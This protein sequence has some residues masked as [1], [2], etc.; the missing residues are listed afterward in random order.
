VA[1]GVF[2]MW[3]PNLVA[4]G[5]NGHGSQACAVAYLPLALYFWDRLWR[6]QGVLVNGA[7]L[8]ITFGF[9]ML[10]AH[11]Q[12]SYYTYALVG[13][14]AVFFGVAHIVDAARGRR[15]TESPLP[16]RLRARLHAEGT[17]PL[18]RAFADIGFAAFVLAVVVAASLAMCAVLYLP[19][20]DYARY[21]I[22]GASSAGGLDYGYAT[23]WSLHPSE[24]LTFLVPHSFGFGKELYLG[25]MP[26]TD[27]P[28]Y[29]GVVV[30]AFAA[31]ALAGV[32]GRWVG[33]AAFVATVST[34][35]SFGKFLPV[36]YDPMF[37]FLP[38]FSKFRVPVMV[39]IV[40]QLAMVTLFAAGA[41]ALY[42][43][44]G[45]ERAR[46][47]ALRGL[48]LAGVAFLAALF[49]QGYWTGGFVGAAAPHVRA[50]QDPEQQRMVARLAGEF[51]AR[52][53]VQLSAIGLA[54]AGAVFAFAANR[55]MS[56][57]VLAGVVLVLG[58]TDYYRVDRFILH[59]EVFRSH[60]AYR[61]LRA[62]AETAR[63]SQPDQMVEALRSREGP[64][65]IFPMDSPQRPFS[66]FFTTN[67]FM[68]FGIESIG[69]YHPAKL[70]LYEEYMQALAGG[71][72]QGRFELLD[73]MNVR[74]LVTG[75]RLPEQPRF[76]PVWSGRDFEGQSRV[77]YEN[78]GAFPRAWVVG[79]YRVAGREETP[80]LLVGGDID[81]RRVAV[82]ERRPAIEPVPGDSARVTVTRR[83][84]RELVLA[85]E[86]DRP[87]LVVVSEVYYPDWKAAVD[88]VA[89]EVLRAN[90]VLRA[91]A[92]EAGRHE[93]VFSYD[94][95]LL[96]K[97][98]TA[99]ITAFALTA[100][101]LVGTLLGGWKGAPWKR[102]S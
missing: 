87:G 36:L 90:H 83:S 57:G 4:V 28:N 42:T 7:A 15:A 21:S 81:L 29:L 45:G 26:F 74:Y 77:I 70:S 78:A 24:M 95:S 97:S 59:P 91:V 75:T 61:V 55:R 13:L 64:F 98:A 46:R 23:S 38:Y 88:G 54:L 3:M 72:A 6:G 49:S 44:S 32:R 100:L 101:T 50:T 19:V 48:I 96:R 93:V 27:Y 33:F 10:R 35:V 85:V 11:L 56:A 60:D 1:A 53:L 63:Y 51:L 71:L 25:R 52:D 16:P 94:T 18:R 69:G 12:I 80:G 30:L 92:L 43:R 22:R 62:P 17:P 67:R 65:R 68:V 9:S 8:A 99:S 84:A 102:S 82:L 5:A 41:S 58:M 73:M 20:H 79:E 14:H 47:W 89:V 66:V 31:G 37:K 40:Q 2:M 86:L 76:Q 39:L 34:L